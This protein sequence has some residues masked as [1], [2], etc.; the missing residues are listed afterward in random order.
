MYLTIKLHVT[1]FI[2]F[3]LL[4]MGYAQEDSSSNELDLEIVEYLSDTSIFSL[5]DSTI[6]WSKL[7]H[8]AYLKEEIEKQDFDKDKWKEA[9]KGIDYST[10]KEEAEK[11]KERRE[12]ERKN[13]KQN[14]KSAAAWGTA[15]KVI[16]VV[17]G[18]L[19][20]VLLIVHFMGAS[21]IFRPKR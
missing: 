19:V 18:I 16:L 14:E 7:S 12:K 5:V 20:A 11:E 13:R 10:L 21:T 4:P 6:D 8:E 1:I 2:A 15:F 17:A 3:V 9:I